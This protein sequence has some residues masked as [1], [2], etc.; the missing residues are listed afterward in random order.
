MTKQ[1]GDANLKCNDLKEKNGHWQRGIMSAAFTIEQ[2]DNIRVQL[3]ETGIRLMSEV[4]VQHMTVSKL[5]NAAGIAKG[6]FYNFFESK[7]DFVMKYADVLQEN[8]F[9]LIFE[10]PLAWDTNQK[11]W[12]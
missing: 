7:E 6:S 11:S 2:Q 10:Y 8:Y 3:F 4:G 12:K 9:A 1:L 5:T